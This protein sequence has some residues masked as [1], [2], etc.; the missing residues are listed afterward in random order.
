MIEKYE[1]KNQ[2]TAGSQVSL[3][4]EVWV[5]DSRIADRLT[6]VGKADGVIAGDQI[7]VTERSHVNE[8]ISGDRVIIA[9]ANDFPKRAFEI[10]VKNT[11]TLRQ[12]RD[13]QILVNVQLKWSKDYIN[14]LIDALKITSSGTPG[15][16]S[17]YASVI[18]VKRP[19]V[20][21]DFYK[22]GFDDKEKEDILQNRFIDYEPVVQI[23]ALGTLSS[24]VLIRNCYGVDRLIGDMI[25]TT[26][27]GG[28]SLNIRGDRSFNLEL[29]INNKYNNRDIFFNKIDQ[30][31]R[32]EVK[33]VPERECRII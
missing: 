12:G 26:Q 13:P 2:S 31:R 15:F 5:S 24:D 30:I 22:A 8:K 17:N 32:F 9:V 16:F 23:T 14:S 7:A 33:M 18:A 21:S 6:I 20:F 27:Y 3:V 25:E 29:A 1:I 10:E 19:G 28:K 11:Q 4:M